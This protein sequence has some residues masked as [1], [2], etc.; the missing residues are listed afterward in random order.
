MRMLWPSEEV[1]TAYGAFIEVYQPLS[2]AL[3]RGGVFRPL[4]AVAARTL[5]LNDR[6]PNVLTD[7]GLPQALLPKD[8]P[9]ERAR[10]LA[11]DIYRRL[12]EPSEDW[13]TQAGMPPLVHPDEFAARFGLGGRL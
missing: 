6:R 3:K 11:R 4:D 9:G 5:Q 8:W 13:L 10:S 1:A 7:P 2:R 12:A